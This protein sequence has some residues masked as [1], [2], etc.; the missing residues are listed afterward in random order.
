MGPV[1]LE[2]LGQKIVLVHSVTLPRR[3]PSY[4]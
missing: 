2:A 3:N 1:L 4:Q